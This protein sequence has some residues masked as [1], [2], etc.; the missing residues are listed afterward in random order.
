MAAWIESESLTPVRWK[1]QD[2]AKNSHVTTG[3]SRVQ[4]EAPVVR[5]MGPGVCR[6]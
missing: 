3:V 1:P 2:L 6:A 5:A 4:D